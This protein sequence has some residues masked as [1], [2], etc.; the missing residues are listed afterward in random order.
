MENYSP[1]YLSALART[2]LLG[3]PT[4]LVHSW[5][6][7][8]WQFISNF[9]ATCFC[10]KRNIIPEVDEKSIIMFFKKGVMDSSLI[11]KLTVKNPRM[12]EEMLAIANKYA[13]AKEATLDTKEQKKDKESGPSDQPSSSKSHDKKRKENRSVNNIEQS[14]HNKEYRPRLGKFEGFLDWICI[15]HP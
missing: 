1:V 11:R 7:L 9:Q 12:F 4:G 6:H 10:D 2:W 15:F 8:C 13:L 3:L 5:S 14:C